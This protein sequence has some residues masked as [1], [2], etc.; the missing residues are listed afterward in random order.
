MTERNPH[1]KRCKAKSKSTGEQC[2]RWAVPGYDVCYYHGAGGLPKLK[3][4]PGGGRAP[5]GN[6]NAR[7]HGAY[8]ARLM[9][10]EQAA[11]EEI[12]AQ[13]EA[14]L[15]A[16]NLTT[17]DQRLIHQFAIVS[18]KFDSA[19]EKG[20]PP[21]ALNTLNRMVLELLREL[22]ATRASKEPQQLVI[23]SPAQ[24]AGDLLA[25][26]KERKPELL[27]HAPGDNGNTSTNEVI[28]VEYEVH[29]GD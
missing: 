28:D 9:P 23:G 25:K 12:K 17:S 19:V 26:I 2:K 8:S 14:E 10:D 21:D 18:T 11:Y 16:E 6:Q 27:G 13:L 7:K 22:K 3:P 1:K 15:G 24:F 5:K 20:A 4:P 29:D